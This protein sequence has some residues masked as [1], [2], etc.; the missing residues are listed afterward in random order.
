ML[1][2]RLILFLAFVLTTIF[3]ARNLKPA[4]REGR[5]RLHLAQLCHDDL[6]RG[7]LESFWAQ[8]PWTTPRPRVASPHRPVTAPR[9]VPPL[10]PGSFPRPGRRVPDGAQRASRPLQLELLGHPDRQTP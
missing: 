10:A 4:L 1:V 6:V 8:P 5:T 3:F 2:C 7:G 9:R